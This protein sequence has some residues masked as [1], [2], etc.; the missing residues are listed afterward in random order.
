MH[1]ARYVV[2]FVGISLLC[3]L[4]V[5][6]AQADDRFEQVAAILE[7]KCVNCHNG[8]ERKGGLS[9][10]TAESLLKGGE[11]GA[12]IEARNPD[13][14]L[15]VEY[16][17]GDKP[18]MPKRG[19]KLTP[20]EVAALKS[21]IA[22]GA[23]WPGERKLLDKF[24]ASSDWWSLKPVVRPALPTLSATNQGRVRTPI[25]GFVLAKLEEHK[26]TM[27]PEAD[28]RTLIRRVFF[29]LVG[30]P[31]TPEA[32]DAFV[33]DTNPL[34]YEK[35]V[36]QLLDSPGY[37][38]RWARHWLDVV[39]YGDTH[40]YD[41][42][43][44]RPYAYPYRDYVI[45]AFN[46]DKPYTR[47]V[48][49]QL[50]GDAL[51]PF[52]R[53]GIEG[54][55]FI[56]A[57][58]W[59]FVGHAEVGEEKLDGQIARML[60][61][62]DMVSTTMNAF[63]STT[64][65]C[66]RCHNHKFD[67]ITTDNYYGLQTVFA[68]VDRAD[69]KYDA[70]P[71]VAAKRGELTK[72]VSQ[73][74]TE[75]ETTRA[76]MRELVGPQLAVIE[77]GIAELNK[78]QKPQDRPEYGY[79][80]GIEAN[81]DAAKWVQVELKESVELTHVMIVGCNDNFNNI[82]AG[83]GFPARFKIE[84]S[85]DP[86]FKFAVTAITDQTA[87]DY[88]NPGVTPQIFPAGGKG[89][90]IRVTATK[91]APRQ[92]DYIFALAEL[93]AVSKAGAN[94]ALQ[95]K[96][97]ALDSIEAPSRWAK[98]NLTDGI[99]TGSWGEDS[100]AQLTKLQAE[101]VAILAKALP[102]SLQ[103]ELANAEKRLAEAK[104][105]FTALP[106]QQMIYC[107]TVHTG[108]GAF[109]GTGP[110]GKP[111][112]IFVLSRG[113]LLKKIKP[114][115]P[116]A[117]PFIP[118]E[119]WQFN[120]PENHDE[121]ARR[122]ALAKWITDKRNPLTWRSIVNRVWQFHFGRG[123]VESANDFGRMGAL[124]SHPELLDWMAVEFRDG[125]QSLKDLHR[126]ILTSATYRQASTGNTVAE[127][128]DGGNQY[129]WRQNRRRLEAEAI[130]DATLSVAGKL[131][132][133]MYGPGYRPFGFMDDH[134]PHYRYHEHNPDD[135]ASH[136][137][138]VYRFVVRSVPDPFMETLDCADPSA[139]VARRNETLT[140]LQALAMLNN[141]FMVRMSEHFAARAATLGT[142]PDVQVAAAFRLA[143]GRVPTADEQAVLATVATKQGLSSACRVI[144]NSN[145]FLFV[146]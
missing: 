73:C 5:A 130:H 46:E 109:R 122:V 96:V 60:D 14:S 120:L 119:S 69:R 132:R 99:Y 3:G 57:G 67:P 113:D 17:S 38:E 70:D 106:P 123:I 131:D 102:L 84:I 62:D 133:T 2:L 45:R 104:Q 98:A 88:K 54:T 97:T 111:R 55:G 110:Q 18:E 135:P 78:G 25:D 40:G 29:D 24:V 21:W 143:L 93:T 27:S 92:N 61:R 146:D 83:F 58:P 121:S 89:K 26:L 105:A 94:V 63:V 47:F 28:R 6:C 4:P 68:A 64:A 139:L 36:D 71:A 10:E 43:K 137:R 39:H 33:Q 126:I 85:D 118:G 42:D 117:A 31:P 115:T 7:R 90:F 107:G 41:K 16:V 80:S 8:G 19:E 53:D 134:S 138:S 76:K 52:T 129:Y 72:L 20:A 145:E 82:G 91:L 77:A 13:A 30:L 1:P 12:V 103:T 11:S 95:G 79:H 23:S 65:Q 141:K 128:I 44:V 56:A 49:E 87:Q 124:P 35:L 75:L 37:G 125:K 144:L 112:E 34:A 127:Q 114:A 74:E 116:G 101:R 48:E 50:A 86:E 32:I 51:Y 140:P 142:A 100:L 59:D 66:A 15:M 9:L 81:Q 136:R 108:T 22:A